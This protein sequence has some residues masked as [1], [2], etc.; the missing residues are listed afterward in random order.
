M[1]KTS[2]T[3][4]YPHPA[5]EKLKKMQTV[6]MQMMTTPGGNVGGEVRASEALA[7]GG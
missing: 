4:E 5:P 2:L 1:H 3:S 7:A 6:K